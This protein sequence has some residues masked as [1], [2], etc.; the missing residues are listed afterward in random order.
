MEPANAVLTRMIASHDLEQSVL[1]LGFREDVARVFAA[2]EVHLLSSRSEAFG[3]V[4]IEAMASGVPCAATDVGESRF[5]IGDTGRVVP[6]RDP[7]ALA[8][9]VRELIELPQTEMEALR[10][11]GR[12]RAAECFTLQATIAQYAELYETIARS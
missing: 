7:A 1:R 10:V 6:P 5:I 11:R 3:N 4:L 2:L 12:H 9:A 8:A